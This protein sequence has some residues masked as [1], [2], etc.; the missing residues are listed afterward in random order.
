[1]QILIY[2]LTFIIV[3]FALSIARYAQL[4]AYTLRIF[5]DRKY[6]CVRVWIF[7]AVNGARG[8]GDKPETIKSAATRSGGRVFTL[9]LSFI[10]SALRAIKPQ[11]P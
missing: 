3:I 5:T 2:C 8:L 11:N 10:S 4:S 6:V 7:S 1:M 9:T